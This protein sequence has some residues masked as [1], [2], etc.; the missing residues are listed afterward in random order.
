M[1]EQVGDHGD[2]FWQAEFLKMVDWVFG[3]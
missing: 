3:S 2:P 1:S